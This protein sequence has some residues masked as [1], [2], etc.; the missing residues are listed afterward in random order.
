V[1]II[2]LSEG[3]I[4]NLHIALKGPLNAVFLKDLADETLRGPRG[5]VD[6]GTSGGRITYGY[7]V[8]KKLTLAAK[9]FAVSARSMRIMPEL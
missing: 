7:E 8:V 2:A 3:E 4:S 9:S 1:K 5:R 6:H